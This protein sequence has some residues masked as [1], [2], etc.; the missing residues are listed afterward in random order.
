MLLAQILAL[1]DTVQEENLPDNGL[2]FRN[3]KEL[4]LGQQLYASEN[5]RS[6][7]KVTHLACTDKR[8]QSAFLL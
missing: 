6:D 8:S 7:V 5:A 4:P 1:F 3:L 2:R